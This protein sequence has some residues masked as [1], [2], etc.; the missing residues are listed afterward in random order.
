MAKRN[1]D[2]SFQSHLK[3]ETVSKHG[4][5]NFVLESPT[6]KSFELKQIACVKQTWFVTE[7]WRSESGM[8]IES[9]RFPIERA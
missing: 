5:S 6:L 2:R 7:S 8:K 9:K 4:N 1:I 3:A